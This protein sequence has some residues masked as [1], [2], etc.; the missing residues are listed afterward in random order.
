MWEHG[1]IDM[2]RLFTELNSMCDDIKQRDADEKSV[3]AD[4]DYVEVSR[5]PAAM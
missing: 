1:Y 5:E 4:V 2:I 3:V